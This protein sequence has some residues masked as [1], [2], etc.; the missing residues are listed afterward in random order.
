MAELEQK[1]WLEVD[2]KGK[3]GW[4]LKLMLSNQPPAGTDIVDQ[5]AQA[6]M[7]ERSRLRPS[8][9]ASTAA[10]RGLMN[11][12]KGFGNKLKLDFKALEVMEGFRVSEKE[13]RQFLAERK[14]HD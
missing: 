4:M 14:T 13:A 9:F 10:A 7:Q 1:G 12:E 3:K 6:I 11:K 5:K 2:F 8:A